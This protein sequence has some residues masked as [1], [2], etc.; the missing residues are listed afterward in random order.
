MASRQSYWRF[1]FFNLS[2]IWISRS[3]K[4][5]KWFL[6]YIVFQ[7][8][9]NAKA[10]VDWIAWAEPQYNFNTMI[11]EWCKEAPKELDFNLEAGNFLVLSK[12]CCKTKFVLENI[13][14]IFYWSELL[15]FSSF[16]LYLVLSSLEISLWIL[17]LVF[18]TEFL[19]GFLWLVVEKLMDYLL[20]TVSFWRVLYLFL[21]FG[22]YL[23]LYISSL[24]LINTS[25]S[26]E[27]TRTVAKNLGCRNQDDD[28]FLLRYINI[29][30]I[31]LDWI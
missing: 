10:I 29:F 17:S 1:C 15:G 14:G 27:N 16:Y 3:L 28:W 18:I 11:D 8:L 13:F 19:K 12:L 20:K 31:G 2:N 30:G 26:V 7:D 22:G 25:I 23:L 5:F 9:K 24:A 6:T 4:A 21:C